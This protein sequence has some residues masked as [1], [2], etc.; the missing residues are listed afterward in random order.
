M[1]PLAPVSRL[2]GEVGDWAAVHELE[3]FPFVAT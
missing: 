2:F 1:A 3:S